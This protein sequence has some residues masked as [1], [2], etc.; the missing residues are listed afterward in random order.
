LFIASVYKSNW[1]CM[2]TILKSTQTG[3][4]VLIASLRIH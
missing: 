3:L 4:L 2:L 1:F